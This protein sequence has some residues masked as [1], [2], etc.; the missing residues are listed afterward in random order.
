MRKA[1]KLT[2]CVFVQQLHP[3]ACVLGKPPCSPGKTI[4][5]LQSVRSLGGGLHDRTHHTQ[6]HRRVGRARV[7][8]EE[9]LQYSE[10]GLTS[11][12]D[13]IGDPGK[14]ANGSRNNRTKNS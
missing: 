10:N 6:G 2:M 4:Q 5:N 8:D 13:D 1:L 3:L 12:R 14:P 9:T 11:V 7:L